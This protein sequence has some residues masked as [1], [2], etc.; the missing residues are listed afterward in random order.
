[1]EV[2]LAHVPPSCLSP[3]SSSRT[4]MATCFLN[5]ASES[6]RT[7]AEGF[8]P[9][10]E[11]GFRGFTAIWY[12][13]GACKKPWVALAFFFG[14]STAPGA[15]QYLKCRDGQGLHIRTACLEV[16]DPQFSPGAS[17]SRQ[18]C[19]RTRQEAS[20]EIGLDDREFA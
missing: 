17:V 6:N 14:Q 9:G 4:C 13:V 19:E 1:M 15:S 8:R 10:L 5:G 7:V 16:V 11:L 20:S 2:V 18:R 12:N 3:K